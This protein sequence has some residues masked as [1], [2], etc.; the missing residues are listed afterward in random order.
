MRYSIK[1]K[2]NKDIF[3]ITGDKIIAGVK[4][5]PEKGKANEELVKKLAW[6]FKVPI[7]SVRI[8]SGRTSRNKVIEI[9]TG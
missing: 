6:H 4:A 7:S 9:P 1:V 3:E 8:V 2:F 5:K